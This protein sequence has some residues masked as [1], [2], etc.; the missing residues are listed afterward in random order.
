MSKYYVLDTICN[1]FSLDHPG[2]RLDG[3]AMAGPVNAIPSQFIHTI[4]RPGM[5]SDPF[6][7]NY[8]WL[9]REDDMRMHLARWL[10]CR[11]PSTMQPPFLMALAQ[12]SLLF[13]ATFT[14]RARASELLTQYLHFRSPLLMSFDIE[15][16]YRRPSI[17][18]W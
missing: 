16:I 6:D 4:R 18:A 13:W 10:A 1:C 12:L 11:N 3:H 9:G 15:Y 17:I 7:L 5:G 8:L 14:M 2:L